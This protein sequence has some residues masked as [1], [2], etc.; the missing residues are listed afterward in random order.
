MVAKKQKTEKLVRGGKNYRNAC[1]KIP[2]DPQVFGLNEGVELVRSIAYAK[3]DETINFTIRL[4]VDPRHSDQ[5]VRGMVS[6]PNG[7]GRSVRVAVFAKDAKAKEALEAGADIVGLEEL[8]ESINNGVINFDVCIASPDMM[9]MVGRVAKILGP[10]GL[11]PNPKLGTVTVNVAEAVRTAKAGQ[12]EF[13]TEKAG[14][15]HAGIAKKSFES[16]A[17]AENIKALVSAIVKAKPA[18][19][20][21]TYLKAAYLSSTMGPSIELDVSTLN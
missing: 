7:T 14:I 21:G 1:A 5:M 18:A 15:V 10:K 16:E 2:S 4:G 9:A 13:R 17:I 6:M 12:V 3:F 19:S 11:M 20:K 8:V